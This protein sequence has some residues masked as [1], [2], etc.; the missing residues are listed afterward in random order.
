MRSRTKKF[1]S[2][3]GL[4]SIVLGTPSA[5]QALLKLDTDALLLPVLF[6][7]GD[8]VLI[9]MVVYE[10]VPKKQRKRKFSRDAGVCVFFYQQN[11]TGRDKSQRYPHSIQ[12]GDS[13]C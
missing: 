13:Y 4:A 12:S 3:V 10:Q 6:V 11:S 1:L 9:G 5:L 2:V 7:I 8:C